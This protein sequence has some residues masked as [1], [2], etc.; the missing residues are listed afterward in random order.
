MNGSPKTERRLPGDPAQGQ[1]VGAVGVDLEL[2]DRVVHAE[3]VERVVAG[4]TR[5]GRQHDDAV[6]IGAQPELGGRADHPGRQ[7]PV[8][9]PRADLEVAGQHGS[10]QADHDEVAL[11]EV[12]RAADDPLGLAGAVGVSDVDG[13]PVDGL[14]VLLRLLVDGEH[15]AHHERAGDRVGRVGDRLELEPEHRQPLGERAHRDVGRQVDVLAN[16]GQWR[17]H[18]I[19]VPNALAKRT[20]PSK[21]SR[22]SVTLWRNISIRS[23]PKPNAI[24]E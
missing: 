15:P 3:H 10:G 11:D 2:D 17:P 21:T 4:R 20:S 22:R 18:Q 1:C 12:V 14:A 13:A 24:P 23:M 16:P 5:V 7:V 8:G 9:L 19:S 6:V